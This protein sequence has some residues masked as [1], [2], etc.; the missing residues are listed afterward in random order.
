MR[1]TK[2]WVEE[3]CPECQAV[4][5]AEPE[6]MPDSVAKG[7]R[8]PNGHWT[9]IYRLVKTRKKGQTKPADDTPLSRRLRAAGIVGETQAYQLMAQA[10]LAGYDKAMETLPA[11]SMSRTL[12]E[13][14]FGKVP[15]LAREVLAQ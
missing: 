3:T 7:K 1:G 9:P 12:V 10:L 6:L 13:G 8:C 5:V 15:A 11:G 4:F 2:A 14:A